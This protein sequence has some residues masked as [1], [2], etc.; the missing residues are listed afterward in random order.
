MTDKKIVFQAT[1][2]EIFNFLACESQNIANYYH[3]DWKELTLEQ[4]MD[5][6]NSPERQKSVFMLREW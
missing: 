6:Y 1:G 5:Y 3:V 2:K 4:V